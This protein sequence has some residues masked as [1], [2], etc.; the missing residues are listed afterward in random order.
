MTGVTVTSGKG[1]ASITP[2]G[3][4]RVVPTGKYTGAIVVTYTI[5]D[6][7]GATATAHITVTAAPVKVRGRSDRP[8]HVRRT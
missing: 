8:A 7:A 3:R 2:D 6:A 5:A 4:V 1:S